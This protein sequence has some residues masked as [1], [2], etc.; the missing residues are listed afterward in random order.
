MCIRYS[1]RSA[2]LRFFSEAGSNDQ[3]HPSRT[4]VAHGDVN[5]LGKIEEQLLKISVGR[6]SADCC[7]IL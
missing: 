6:L 2:D 1:V 4:A 7:A 5:V 3:M